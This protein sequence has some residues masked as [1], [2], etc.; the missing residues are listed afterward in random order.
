[1]VLSATDDQMHSIFVY[2]DSKEDETNETSVDTIQY[3]IAY[4]Q[5]RTK[6]HYNNNNFYPTL[7]WLERGWT[8]E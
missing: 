5:H 1:M 3:N 2:Q 8:E 4:F 6:L 7:G